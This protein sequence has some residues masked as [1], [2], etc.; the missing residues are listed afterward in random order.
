MRLDDRVCSRWFAVEQ[1]LRQGCVLA[2][3]LFNIFFAAVMN[4]AYAPFKADKVIMDA[5]VHPRKKKGAG[6]RG[7]ATVG[8]AAG[9]AALGHALC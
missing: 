6:G 5:L 1:G 9:D 2:P 4:V 7:K 3:L 8:E